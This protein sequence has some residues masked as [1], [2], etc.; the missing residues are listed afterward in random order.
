MLQQW[1][2]PQTVSCCAQGSAGTVAARIKNPAHLPAGEGENNYLSLTFDFELRLNMHLI[3]LNLQ[4]SAAILRS[5]KEQ[6]RNIDSNSM[7]LM[8]EN[9]RFPNYPKLSGRP[10]AMAGMRGNGS[11]EFPKL[12]PRLCSDML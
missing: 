5:T 4:E 9:F 6:C 12:P 7:L 3:V 1:G 10:N 2:S 8:W 11:T